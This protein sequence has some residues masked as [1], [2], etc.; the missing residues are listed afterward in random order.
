MNEDKNFCNLHQ[1][2][3]MGI[4]QQVEQ[5]TWTTRDFRMKYLGCT[6]SHGRKIK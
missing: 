2:M 3:T 6:I 1:N 5:S 4:S